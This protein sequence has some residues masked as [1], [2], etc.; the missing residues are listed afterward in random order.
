V[1]LKNYRMSIP[2]AEKP[3]D[4]YHYYILNV[5]RDAIVS[6][7]FADN[8]EIEIFRMPRMPRARG[9]KNFSLAAFMA[10]FPDKPNG[11]APLE[12][13]PFDLEAFQNM[14]DVKRVA[15]AE[16]KFAQKQGPRKSVL[17]RVLHMYGQGSAPYTP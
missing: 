8:E 3:D 11:I 9:L 12:T 6:T 14:D 15:A 10:D 7:L 13:V 2:E 16:K 4:Q 5:A 17:D 1:E